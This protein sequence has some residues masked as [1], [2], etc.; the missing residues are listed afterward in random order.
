M[1]IKRIAAV[2]L[3][4]I[5]TFQPCISYAEESSTE[6]T[7]ETQSSEVTSSVPASNENNTA[8]STETATNS[9]TEEAKT[10][11]ETVAADKEVVLKTTAQGITVDITGRGLPENGSVSITEVPESISDQVTAKVADDKDISENQIEIVKAIDIT[12]HDENGNEFEPDQS[13]KVVISN[14]V[15]DNDG[16]FDVY[17]VDEN[18]GDVKGIKAVDSNIDA[19]GDVSFTADQFSPYYIL[20]T[21]NAALTGEYHA[22]NRYLHGDYDFSYTGNVQEWTC[23]EDG[24]Y[25]LETIGAGC[26]GSNGS[27]VLRDPNAGNV[28]TGAYCGQYGIATVDLKKNDKLYIVVGG[29]GSYN[30]VSGYNSRGSNGKADNCSA[31]GDTLIAY[32]QIG[33]CISSEYDNEAN[34]LLIEVPGSCGS[35]KSYLNED[36]CNDKWVYSTNKKYE[37][38]SEISGQTSSD[39][40][41]LVFGNGEAA[42]TRLGDSYSE[43]Q[44]NLGNVSYTYNGN[45]VSG[46]LNLYGI[47]GSEFDLSSFV[48]NDSSVK[49]LK[50]NMSLGTGTVSNGFIFTFGPTKSSVTPVYYSDLHVVSNVTPLSGSNYSNSVNLSFNSVSNGTNRAYKVFQAI[51]SDSYKELSSDDIKDNS[52]SGQYTYNYSG[53]VECFTAPIDGT[54]H[55]DA[56]GSHGNG[57]ECSGGNGGYTYGDITLKKDAKIYICVGGTES[58]SAS[59]N[60]GS[61]RLYDN[62]NAGN[63]GG[64]T[65]ITTTDRGILKN[66]ASYQDEV[67]MVAG[68]GGGGGKHG[69]GGSGNAGGGYAFGEG[70]SSSYSSTSADGGVGGGGWSGGRKAAYGDYGAYGG[71]GHLSSLVTNGKIIAGGNSGTGKV[72]ITLD[73]DSVSKLDKNYCITVCDDKKPNAPST[74]SIKSDDAGSLIIT[75]NKPTDNGTEYKHYIQMIDKKDSSVISTSNIVDDIILSDIAGYYYRFDSVEDG[76]VTNS[77]TLSDQSTVSVAIPEKSNSV[78]CHVAA[79]DKAGNISDTYTFAVNAADA[80]TSIKGSVNWFDSN[81]SHKIRPAKDTVTLLQDGKAYKTIDVD[82]SNDTSSYEFDDVPKGHTYDIT[83]SVITPYECRKQSKYDLNNILTYVDFDSDGGSSADSQFVNNGS[84]VPKPSD[85]SWDNHTFLGWFI[86]KDDNGTAYDFSSAV[87]KSMTL[88]AH[89][90]LNTVTVKFDSNGGSSVEDEIVPYGDAAIKPSDPTKACTD[91]CP[92]LVEGWYIDPECTQPYDFSKAVLADMTLFAKW[93]LPNISACV[94]TKVTAAV[95]AD[96]SI[97][98]PTDY[99]VKSTTEYPIYLK[100]DVTDVNKSLFTDPSRLDIRLNNNTSL[101]GQVINANA[102]YNIV[103]T[104]DGKSA[105]THI[106]DITQDNQFFV[107][108]YGISFT[109]K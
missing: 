4:F 32:T 61:A 8:E 53:H 1:K 40:N 31:G 13:V 65:S 11:T 34:K 82:T 51:D 36:T 28:I 2:L 21:S 7:A 97:V 3:S 37:I 107:I 33:D 49:I 96:G 54:Y 92:Y 104:A 5:I 83:Q 41:S 23:P 44:L 64:A 45:D 19:D 81:N 6:S 43:I 80:Y 100:A 30:G 91:T 101:S 88:Y 67:L 105:G 76:T 58:Y 15:D 59:Y 84:S 24:C 74:N 85:P 57:A 50:W 102:T 14:A 66:F 35:G 29:A 95:N 56:Y 72:I 106:D 52:F 16:N 27:E 10:S 55:I 17:H 48:P 109:D 94:P 63:G 87:T 108:N 93:V 39:V 73:D 86:S 12:I 75:W 90:K 99:A 26:G 22:D 42:I 25:K 18:N 78:Y 68:G 38:S 103:L 47:I 79:V 9:N 71:T 98:F 60:N 46:I 77:D 20:K 62:N 69:S 89:W 70:V